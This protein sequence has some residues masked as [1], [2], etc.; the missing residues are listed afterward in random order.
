MHDTSN[1]K[2]LS[3]KSVGS[4]CPLY[5]SRPPACSLLRYNSGI[6]N[7]GSVCSQLYLWYWA[8]SNLSSNRGNSFSL[9]L[10][11]NFCTTGTLYGFKCGVWTVERVFLKIFAE[12]I[13][14]Q[15]FSNFFKIFNKL[16]FWNE[17]FVIVIALVFFKEYYLVVIMLLVSQIS[18]VWWIRRLICFRIG[19]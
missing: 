14:F 4:P 2:E 5:L 17:W 16:Q 13:N 6:R 18:W 8:P 10:K 7:Q 15:I 1:E 3:Q 9:M 11:N 12:M 19:I